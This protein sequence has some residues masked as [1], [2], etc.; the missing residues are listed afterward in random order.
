MFIQHKLILVNGQYPALNITLKEGDILQFTKIEDLNALHSFFLLIKRKRLRQQK[1]KN[2]KYFQSTKLLWMSRQQHLF[3]KTDYFTQANMI[4][5]TIG[6]F[7]SFTETF[8]I[9]KYERYS[10]VLQQSTGRLSK[11]SKLLSFRY[12]T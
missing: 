2:F 10:H 6:H 4:N 5:C 8:G 7:D 1:Q 11:L 12:K 9:F 3:K